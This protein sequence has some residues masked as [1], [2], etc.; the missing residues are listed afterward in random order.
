MHGCGTSREMADALRCDLNS[1]GFLLL[2]ALMLLRCVAHGDVAR[3]A[4]AGLGS[5]S[6]VA[7]AR[8]R[9]GAPALL[10]NVIEV[11]YPLVATSACQ[12]QPVLGPRTGCCGDLPVVAT[13]WM[14]DWLQRA[15]LTQSMVAE[16]M[17]GQ[18]AA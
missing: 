2:T 13:A 3:A 17:T 12:T 11:L 4:P 15:S 18:D 10:L 9:R 1:A 7:D 14:R 16:L 8:L 6:S 5:N